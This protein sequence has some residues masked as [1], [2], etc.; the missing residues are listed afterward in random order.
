M[1]VAA[2]WLL[3]GQVYAAERAMWVWSMSE[4]IVLDDPPGSR[5][6]F[7][8]F[9][10]S[11]H[12]NSNKKVTIVYL[13]STSLSKDLVSSYPE[14]LRGF[15][16]AAHS[17][18]LK[19]ECLD[20]DKSWATPENRNKGESRCDE[21]L[22]FN[23]GSA[24]DTERFDGI[25]YDVEPHGLHYS[26]GD[27]YDW[28]VDNAVIWP[29]YLTLLTNCQAK[30][31]TY[32]AS[33][34]P[35]KFG[36]D[37]A[38]W[39]DVD[40]YPGTPNDV[41]TRV[42]YVTLMDYR[43]TGTL[44][45]DGVNTE[46]N[47][48][49]A[50]GKK[51][52]IGVE[53]AP[54]VLPDPQTVTFFE[55]GNTYME[56]QLTYAHTNLSANASY[57][58]AAIHY[59]EDVSAQEWAYRKLW[60]DTFPGYPP[61]VQVTFPNGDEGI[62]LKP[63][64]T[65]NITWVATDADDNAAN[66]TIV[67]AC[68]SNG[69][70]T[71][72]TIATGEA[73][74]GSYTWNTTGLPNGTQYRI[75]VTATDPTPLSGYDTSDYNFTFSSAPSPPPDWSSA[76]DTVVNGIRPII[77]P[78]GDILHMIWYWPGWGS[79][80]KGIYYK[81]STDR[82]GSW[83][84]T[85]TLAENNTTE[86]RKPALAVR[87]NTVAVIWVEDEASA[88]DG[89]KVKVRISANGGDSWNAAEEVQ[90]TYTYFK[91]ADFPAISIDAS[92]NIH[93]VWGARNT[94]GPWY[95]HYNSK[96]GTTWS[97]V[98]AL[99]SM[100]YYIATPSI[101]TDSNG[102]HVVWG[103]FN[104]FSGFQCRIKYR[105]KSGGNWGG[106]TIIT[107]NTVTND[108]WNKYFPKICSD[109][110]NK[111]HVVWQTSGDNPQTDS[112]PVTSDVYY[113][114][115]SNGGDA[116]SS[117][118]NLGDGYVPTGSATS[119]D[120]RVIY[121]VPSSTAEKG[122]IRYRKSADGGGSWSTEATITTD[123]PMPYWNSDVSVMMSFPYIAADSLGN[124][125][126]V[127]R[128]YS[129]EHIMCSYK[130]EY[131]S[132]V[133]LFS[134]LVYNSSNSL[135]LKWDRPSGYTPNS[136][137]LYRS[138]NGGSYSLA[139]SQIYDVEY[140]D[141]G[142]LNTS[143]YRYKVTAMEGTIESRFSNISNTLYPGD[144]FLL[145]YFEGYEGINYSKAGTS[146]LT[147]AYDIS[148]KKEGNQSMKLNYTYANDGKWG[149]ALKGAMPVNFDLLDYWSVKFWAMGGV[150]GKT[151][152]AFQFTE[153]GRAE[154]NETW[155][156]PSVTVT[157]TGWAEYNFNFSDFVRVDVEPTGGGN[158]RI[159]TNS[160]GAYGLV[161]DSN[162]TA[163]GTYYVDGIRLLRRQAVI[164]V[165]EASYTF[166]PVP[167]VGSFNDHRFIYGP[168][169]VTFGG[170]SLNWTVRIWTNN[171][172][173]ASRAD[174]YKYAG[175]RG[176]DA[177]TYIPLKVW[178]ANYGP[179]L[180]RP[181]P[182][183]PLPDTPYPDEENDYFYIGYDFGDG[184]NVGRQYQDGDKNDWY[185]SGTFDENYWGFDINGNGVVSDVITAS[186]GGKIGE[187]PVWLRIPEYNEM[188]LADKL[189]WRRL[190][191]SSGA[192][193]SSP[194]DIYLAIDVAGKGNQQYQTT[195]LTVEYINE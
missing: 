92:S 110:S 107:Q 164:S 20:G 27:S 113:S 79:L 91:W 132:P 159:D 93:V 97:G 175:L 50:L 94:G 6:E 180:R 28:D 148:V 23:K 134:N 74:D 171:N 104:W 46:I 138:Q 152:V 161:F 55:E 188:D 95:I 136:Y 14:E 24:S 71:W 40:S 146:S 73:N 102:A 29:Q 12:G 17:R 150:V 133:N 90:G 154:G 144:I 45:V 173:T 194:F 111:L 34:A 131:G 120:L 112:P 43:Q 31:N 65:Y 26:K 121:Y 19:V 22:N 157:N 61:A 191:Y 116:W 38:W 78:N 1:L 51:V 178:C 174:A 32:N 155:Q 8:N 30:V 179:P 101:T 21:I 96:S 44:I 84:S 87:G 33:Y 135:K 128:G 36:V 160:I 64:L 177:V 141:T 3:A 52:Y 77:I 182:P 169:P 53:T 147:W 88:G 186:R 170:Y 41:Q 47:N 39:Y 127:W 183:P 99:D 184:V 63:D 4:D 195:T 118:V 57:G 172:P 189:T 37:I 123:A 187:E 59:Y 49:N 105:K 66:L 117:P 85:V 16:A 129:N 143:Y 42:D 68:S 162:K 125:L 114:S 69:G 156:S 72:T 81:K 9:C 153:I 108:I 58:G 140:K 48:G 7:F 168:I 106:I 130:G 193:L 109:S 181:V 158:F 137:S 139:A 11:P 190:C 126:M 151:A 165:P 56:E 89:K 35:I 80:P 100:D 2:S 54:A 60:T 70:S 103:E 15:L 149:A 124:M 163:D 86:P 18:G 83:T 67:I 62:E 166:Q 98:V 185:L 167:L 5:A 13:S 76:Q 75:K 25:H 82:G 176:A 192:E 122:D 119:N 10:D 142:L 145:D 115:N